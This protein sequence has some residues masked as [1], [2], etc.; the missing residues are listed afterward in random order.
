MLTIPI[1]ILCHQV[2]CMGRMGSGI[3]KAIK[4]K[5]PVV[6]KEYM[7]YCSPRL[8]DPNFQKTMLG[9]MQMVSVGPGLVV[10][11]MFGQFGFGQ[12][13]IQYTN[14]DAVAL[15]FEDLANVIAD[16]A[17][18]NA[19]KIY[20]PYK[21]GCGLGGGDWTEYQA[22]IEKFIPTAKVCQL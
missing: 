6:Y 7:E 10:C 22:I 16:A 17:D 19:Y 13:R 14:Y 18:P 9:H 15:A 21:M 3:A 8:I 20:V 12:A 1:G 5:W 4:E 11:N 2:N